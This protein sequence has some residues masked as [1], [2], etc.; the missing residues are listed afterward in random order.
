MQIF[1]E[2]KRALAFMLLTRNS[3][4]D[5]KLNKILKIPL[6]NNNLNKKKLKMKWQ[7]NHSKTVP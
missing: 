5:T 3:S 6:K 2:E 7:A 4:V 1:Q